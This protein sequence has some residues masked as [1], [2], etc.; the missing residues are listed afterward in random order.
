VVVSRKLRFRGRK[1]VL[2]FVF[3]VATLNLALGMGLAIATSHPWGNLRFDLRS[4]FSLV[5][6]RGPQPVAEQ[7]VVPAPISESEP[8]ES[9][10]GIEL[11]PGWRER[12]ETGSVEPGS[13][14]EAVLHLIRL[15]DEAFRTRWMTV[16]SGVRSTPRHSVEEV[17]SALGPLRSEATTWMGWA[18]SLLEDLALVRE[19]IGNG[20]ACTDQVEELLLDQM[21]RI[22]SLR[23]K[24]DAL[25]QEPDAEIGMRR[26][27]RECGTVYE[28]S[29]ALRDLVLDQLAGLLVAAGGVNDMPSAWQRDS[30]TGY[31]NRLGLETALADWA[32][33]DPPRKRLIS[34]AFVEVDRLGKLNERLGVQQSDHVI[35]AFAKLV[36]GVVRSDRGDRVIRVG[37]PTLFVL[38]AD[39]GVAGAK[40]AAERIRQTVEAATF[41]SLH[42]EFTLAANCSVCDYLLDDTTSALLERLRAGIAEVKRGGRNRTAIDEGQ[43]PVLFEAQPIQVR[44]QT[45]KVSANSK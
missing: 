17:H 11:P 34:G 27:L 16:E 33:N 15:E 13:V 14:V 1:S 18:K 40:A 4:L 6:R 38:L 8:A 28:R 45:I 21:S 44:A 42:E 32:A 5:A 25:L 36:E 39:A 43:G 10:A 7:P 35:R 20:Q 26:F 2:F 9:R 12:L 41:Q 30:V 24:H 31:P 19:Q 23:E 37:G 3:I 22:E 29:C